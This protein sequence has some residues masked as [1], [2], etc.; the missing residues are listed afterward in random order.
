M[1]KV[2]GPWGPNQ[3]VMSQMSKNMGGR[4]LGVHRLVYKAKE[5]IWKV[6]HGEAR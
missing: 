5:V 4:T 3:L 1:R 6:L 2:Q